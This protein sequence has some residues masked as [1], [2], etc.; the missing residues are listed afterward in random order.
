[1]IVYQTTKKGFLED[2]SNSIEKIIRSRVKEKLNIDI[3]PGSSEYISWQNSLGRAMYHVL[4]TKNIPDDSGVAVE[5]SIARTKNRI[6]F[7]ITGQDALGKEIAV[8]I[9]LK[10]WTH[11]EITEKDAVVLTRFRHGL[12][13]ELHPSYQAWS[14]ST[15]LQGFNSVVY[16]EG[17]IL[18][19]C[20]Y[21]HN[22]IDESVIKNKF[23]EDYLNKSPAFCNKDKEAL[24]NFIAEHVKYG[25]KKNTLYRIENGEIK[26]SKNLADSLA[27]MIKG[28]QEFVMIDNQKIVYET[29]L[30][31]AKKSSKDNKN[32]LIVE[33]GPGTGKSVVAINLLVA[34]TNLRLNARYVTKNAAPRAV[35]ESKLT[36]T[37]KKTH[38]SNLFTGSGSY[39]ATKENS[40]DSL[41]IDE[42]HRL[43]EKSGIFKSI[44]KS[45]VNQV[46][47]DSRLLKNK[48]KIPLPPISLQQTFATIVEH[49]ERLKEN[50]GRMNINSAEMFDSLMHKA[51]R[52]EL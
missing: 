9:E 31:L 7:I 2:A 51:F 43:N 24:Q 38:I 34:I 6:D 4:N 41:I 40:F 5:Y 42:A 15:L 28:N 13:E 52:G 37:L 1:M 3:K 20:A 25:D 21:L 32:V 30:F 29:G 46:G 50:V 17:I 12:S 19:P 35:F 14:Y 47:I 8:I 18:L 27:S 26:P 36:G 10:Q 44:I 39:V 48:V 11:I 49:V 16:N 33:G 45:W 22:C 23:Y